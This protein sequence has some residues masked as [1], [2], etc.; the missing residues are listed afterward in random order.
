MS[1]FEELK[2]RNV[3]RVGIAYLIVG[4]LLLQVT[5]IV[6]PIMEL[7]NWVAK[8]VL[9][10]LVLGL[11]LVLFFA[12]AFELTPE[13]IKRE[14]EIDRS[15]S[16]TK[17]T[18][19]KL[20]RAII[21]VMAVA[22]AWFAWDKFSRTGPDADAPDQASIEAPASTT[23][24]KSIAVLPFVNM[25]GDT[26]NEYFSDGISEEILNALAKVDDLKVAGRTSS[27]A[28]KGRNEDLRAIGDAL[29]VEHILEGSVRKSG[30]QVRITAQLIQVHDGFHL[31]S[32]TYD[33]ELTNV[34]AIQDEIATAILAELK[35]ELGAGE[36]EALASTQT[37]PQAYQLYLRAKQHIYERTRQSI[38]AAAA[39][40]DSALEI[41]PGYAPALAQRGIA[42]MLLQERNYGTLT[43]EQAEPVARSYLDRALAADPDTAEAWAGLGLYHTNRPRENQLG[44]EA[45]EKALALNPNLIDASN[46]LQLGYSREGEIRK[47]QAILEDMFERDPLYPPVLQ[48][49]VLS[50]SRLGMFD[51]AER[52]IERVAPFLP[53]KTD[54]IGPRTAIL[55]LRGEYAA[56]I[57]LLRQSVEVDPDNGTTWFVLGLALLSTQQYEALL[58]ENYMAPWQRI[59]AL[60]ALGR[61]E[62]ATLSAYE[63]AA[64]GNIGPLL[65][66][67]NRDGRPQE[68]VRFFD[69]RWTSVA[70]FDE[71]YPGGGNGNDDMLELAYAFSETGDQQRYAEAMSVVREDHDALHAQGLVTD[72]FFWR[73][74]FF[75]ALA[76]DEQRALDYLE[77]AV[78]RGSIRHARIAWEFPVFASMEGDPRFDSIQNK[79]IE[80]LNQQ[81]AALGLESVET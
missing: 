31:W 39:M 71:E 66:L 20:D 27:F 75:Y 57:P 35:A 3:F 25:S 13:G 43:R 14:T 36:G 19:R 77:Q 37:D 18:G 80:N 12:W 17:T 28:F 5:D 65:S 34:F 76:G 70:Q 6:V 45:L 7:P 1:F 74:A 58:R 51:Q 9:F 21:V 15:R 62:E 41:D 16:I 50:Y 55:S 54:L 61:A 47:A 64:M 30:N 79:M 53:G 48:N 78:E 29:G 40:L 42:T 63:R 38:E 59:L 23:G 52:A 60:H 2:R 33:R 10:L 26:E 44:I 49:L 4:W 32:D 68:L 11:P 46:W 72:T 69:E 81:R 56:A 24:E 67:L 8:L 22:L 73:E